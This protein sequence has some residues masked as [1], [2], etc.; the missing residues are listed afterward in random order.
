M[1]ENQAQPEV[2]AKLGAE[3]EANPLAGAVAAAAEAAADPL[4]LAVLSA[5]LPG[6]DLGFGSHLKDEDREPNAGRED[7]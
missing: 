5:Q 4:E 2:A 3:V 7:G 6:G 1:I